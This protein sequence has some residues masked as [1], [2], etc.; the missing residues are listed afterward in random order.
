MKR[1]GDELIDEICEYSNI[2]DSIHVVLRGRKRKNTR[3]GRCILRHEDKFIRSIAKRI[4]SG[5]FRVGRYQEMYVTD[6][7][8]VRRVQAIPIIDRIAAN[9]VMSV[10]ERHVFRRYIRTTGASIKRRGAHDLMSI[11][12]RDMN[13]N[14]EEFRYYYQSDFK[15]FYESISQ[16]FLMYSLRKMFKGKILM[17]IIES[18][19]T[20]MPSGISI[21]LRSSQGFGNMLLSMWLDH[22]IKDRLR[23]K[24]YYRYCDDITAVARTKK[25]L[26][27]FRNVMHIKSD[28]IGLTIKPNEC[29]RPISEGLDA[30]GY[31]TYQNRKFIRKRTK[32]NFARK[33]KKLSSKRRRRELTASFYGQCK[34]GDCR[35]L[36]YILTGVKMKDFK[37]LK[38][39]PKYQDN[40]KRFN[41]E[42]VTLKSL[43][44][45][46]VIILDY[47]KGVIPGWQREEYEQEVRKAKDRLNTL[48][49]KYG[50]EIPISE[51]YVLPSDVKKPEGRYIVL[52]EDEDGERKK[53]FTGDKEFWSILDQAEEMKEI[54]FRT[55]IKGKKIGNSLKFYFE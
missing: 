20:M 48:H 6:G 51:K 44:D 36:F 34:H 39:K 28:F 49:Q 19:V 54:P 31:K 8:K 27:R 18:F 45:S 26:W 41:V 9:A 14:P 25:E 3:V 52:V 38:I 16:D 7:P 40:K 24:F 50:N 53:F 23:W 22:Y 43:R 33:I 46:K 30:L 5:K 11:I 10:I 35:N 42:T 13:N 15:K 47:E 55:T 2:S 1:L 32:Q 21:G 12:Q 29:V 4:R 17:G 37:D